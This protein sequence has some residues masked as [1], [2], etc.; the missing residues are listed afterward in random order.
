[1]K[2]YDI[3]WSN[4]LMGTIS[5]KYQ[6]NLYQFCHDKMQTT[7]FDFQHTKNSPGLIPR[8]KKAM[9]LLP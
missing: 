8:L 9:L 6:A 4:P 1:M 2:P 7:Q 3:D 5:Q